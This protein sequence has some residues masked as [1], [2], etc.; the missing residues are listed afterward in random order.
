MKKFSH[1]LVLTLLLSLSTLH[2]TA[3]N[4]CGFVPTEDFMTRLDQLKSVTSQKTTGVSDTLPLAMHLVANDQ[5]VGRHTIELTLRNICDLND[6]YTDAGLYFWIQWPIDNINNS[7]YF[8]HN[9]QGGAQMML[10]NNRNNAI[11]A[12]VVSDPNGTC[13]YYSHGPDAIALSKGCSGIGSMTFA[14]EMGHLLNLPHTFNGWEHGQTPNNPELV[15]RGVGRNCNYTGDHFCD[16]EADYISNRWSCPYTGTKLD[17]NGDSYHPDSSLIMNYAS[18]NCQSRFSPQQKTVM[19]NDKNSRWNSL[20]H[21]Y[22][23]RVDQFD[24][25]FIQNITDTLYNDRKISWNSVPGANAYYI[26]LSPSTSPS[27]VFYETIVYNKNWITLPVDKLFKNRLHHI[28][29]RPLNGSSL[30]GSFTGDHIFTYLDKLGPNGWPTRID[31]V[32]SADVQYY[33]TYEQSMPTLHYKSSA[34]D[35]ISI[36][37]TDMMGRVLAVNEQSISPG[38]SSL[39]LPV[40]EQHRGQ[41]LLVHLTQKDGNTKTLKLLSE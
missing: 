34:S 40:T 24:T 39:V 26:Q 28:R 33:L 2:T 5:G 18:D 14:H 22:P 13:G 23:T 19:I 3:Q 38:T 41:L 35:H 37:I 15:T 25:V 1:L 20:A 29:I 8:V 16:T 31:E 21:N 10:Q 11:N 27:Y 12:Y 4:G 9:F 6:A 7:A 36:N 32:E 30:C 17:A